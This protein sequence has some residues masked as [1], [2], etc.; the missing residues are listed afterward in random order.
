MHHPLTQKGFSLVELVVVIAIFAIL[1][2]FAIP[3]YKE[4]IQ[5]NMIRNTAESMLSGMQIARGEAVKR[6]ASVQFDLR[7]G[8]GAWTV[9][10]S[11]A[12]PGSCPN[13][14]GASTVQSRALGEGASA[15]ITVASDAAGPFV[16]SGLGVMTSPTSAAASGLV[17]INIDNTALTADESRDLRIVIGAGGAVK[18]CD[19][20]L[21]TTGTDPRRCP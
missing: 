9:C 21:S 5:N 4:M 6:N 7:G 1:A 3:S 13:P 16:F 10:V 2:T 19:P 11:P 12:V 17:S 8:N 15:N 14:D 18:L 20:A